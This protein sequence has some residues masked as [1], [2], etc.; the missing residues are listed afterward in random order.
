M[1]NE[2]SNIILKRKIHPKSYRKI[3]KVYLVCGRDE[4]YIIKLHTCNYDIYK[5]L[6]SRKFYHFP[7]NLTYSNDNYDISIYIS[8][9][10]MDK[11]QKL[12]D[13][14]V[15]TSLLHKVTSY[16]REID[17]DD[18]KKI[19]ED[20]NENINNQ[21]IYYSSLNDTY[22][23]TEFLSPSQYLLLRNV[24]L[25]YYLLD[26]SKKMI[27]EW[28]LKIKEKKSIRV[29]LIHNNLSLDHFIVNQDKYLISWDKAMF[30]NPIYDLLH[31]YRLYFKEINLNNLFLIYENNNKLDDLEKKLLLVLLI[32]ND[33][34]VMTNNE[35][36]NTKRINDRITFLEKIYECLKNDTKEK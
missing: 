6:L 25:I 34:I 14:L 33:N 4:D 19:Y 13:L 29:C 12:N 11:Y 30:D 8:D 22:D 28:Y 18:I 2:L 5:Y 3:G 32:T 31:L 16:Q 15:I 9:I 35:L 7:K 21:M 1:N 26:Y 23:N 20:I 10:N 24:S 27:D 17:L 36:I